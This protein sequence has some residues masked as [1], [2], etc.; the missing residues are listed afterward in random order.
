MTNKQ[1]RDRIREARYVP[2]DRFDEDINM[3]LKHLPRREATRRKQVIKG[4]AIAAA[5]VLFTVL[6]GPPIVR[7]ATPLFQRLFGQVVDEIEQQQALPEE[8]KLRQMIAD[9]EDAMREHPV[10]GAS[11]T[12]MGTEVSVGYVSA[13]PEDYANKDG[14]GSMMV[15]LR[16][17]KIPPFDPSWVDFVA[18][19]DGADIPMTL[20]ETFAEH[21]RGGGGQT[22][23]EEEWNDGWS[24]SNSEIFEGQ[25]TTHLQFATKDWRW[26]EPKQ[27]E[28]KAVID[29][30]ALSIPFTFDPV[31]AHETAIERARLS[32]KLGEEN[33]EHEKAELNAMRDGAIPVGLTGSAFGVH[34]TIAEMS[35]ADGKLYFSST[36]DGATIKNT[37]AMPEYS[38]EAASVDGMFARSISWNSD[39]I[40]G[41]QVSTLSNFTLGRDEAKLPASSLIKLSLTLD[42]PDH[43]ADIAFYCNWA[44]KRVTLPKDDAEMAEWV[45]QAAALEQRYLDQYPSAVYYDLSDKD[46]SQTIGGVTMRITGASYDSWG[47]MTFYVA[48]DGDVEACEYNLN[49]LSP[50]AS[51]NG[52]KAEENSLGYNAEDVLTSMSFNPPIHISEFG[53]GNEFEISLPLF[54]KDREVEA[55]TNYPVPDDTATFT[56]AIAE[57]MEPTANPHD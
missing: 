12:I 38:I 26:D 21:Y 54:R 56:F 33:Y 25:P 15:T 13:F 42:T 35:M 2:S 52:K 53:A 6:A 29:G 24:G 22:L 17:D 7:A 11:T 32:V 57:D 5:V 41:D 1:E 34:Y 40:D 55:G 10:E 37:K 9:Y 49:W 14:G 36:C 39:V 18:N 48:F 46:L 20:D 47:T 50:E 4:S 19:V 3:T 27:I 28:I 30:E 31:K 23:T 8:E 16:Y 45:A 44:Q 51:I 43:V